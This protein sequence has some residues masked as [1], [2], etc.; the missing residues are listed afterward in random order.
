MT[1]GTWRPCN[2]APGKRAA[3]WACPGCAAIGTVGGAETSID[4]GGYVMPSVPCPDARF[5]RC[6][7]SDF[8]KLEGW[9]VPAVSQPDGAGEEE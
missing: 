9:P 4:G 3:W 6:P 2:L 7:F 1:R 5:G 8:L